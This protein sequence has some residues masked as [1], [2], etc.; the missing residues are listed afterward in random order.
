MAAAETADFE[1]GRGGALAGFPAGPPLLEREKVKIEGLAFIG[2]SLT[3]N[4]PE[5]PCSSCV[6]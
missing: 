3:R 2:L 4:H 5:Q 1:Y 6:R